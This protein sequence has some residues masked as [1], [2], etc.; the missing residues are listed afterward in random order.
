MTNQRDLSMVKI[1][2]IVFLSTSVILYACSGDSETE[3]N[4]VAEIHEGIW[5]LEEYGYES[6]IKTQVIEEV[7]YEISFNFEGDYSGFLDCNSIF[8]SYTIT[9]DSINIS[10]P[11]ETKIAC[12]NS[13]QESYSDETMFFR[14]TLA[15]ATSYSISEGQLIISASDSSQLLFT[16]YGF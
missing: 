7:R 8:G 11:G 9:L 2:K 13:D 1:L 6:A 10:Y 12:L 16:N 14:E 5:V 15:N 3:L 4:Q